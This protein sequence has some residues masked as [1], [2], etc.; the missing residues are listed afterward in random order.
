VIESK[1]KEA[2]PLGNPGLRKIVHVI[3]RIVKDEALV[4]PE[5]WAL[6]V[7]T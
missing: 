1:L 4:P 5:S 6:I 3:V 2:L 7:V